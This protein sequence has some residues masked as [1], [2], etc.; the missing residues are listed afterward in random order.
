MMAVAA[1]GAGLRAT[2]PA[3]RGPARR[4]PVRDQALKPATGRKQQTTVETNDGHPLPALPKYASAAEFDKT[5]I[6]VASAIAG[7]AHVIVDEPQA[8]PYNNMMPVPK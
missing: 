2:P 8:A 3:A 4:W 1:R 6:G 5:I 7:D